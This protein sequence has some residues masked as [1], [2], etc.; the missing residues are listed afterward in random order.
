MALTL[1]HLLQ[2]WA[3]VA[4]SSEQDVVV[5]QLQL[6]SRHVSEGDIFVAIQGHETDGRI[7]I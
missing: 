2:P 7:F 1:T 5:T 4:L 3:Q 6:D